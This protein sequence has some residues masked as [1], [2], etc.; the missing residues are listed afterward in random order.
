METQA[1]VMDN[2]TSD[3]GF[4]RSILLECKS[5]KS[6]I[7]LITIDKTDNVNCRVRNKSV[8][9]SIN[10]WQTMLEHIDEIEHHFLQLCQGEEADYNQHIGDNLYVSMTSGVMCVDIRK[11]YLDR[12]SSWKP[13]QPGIGLKLSEFRELLTIKDDVNEKLSTCEATAEE[14]TQILTLQP[15]RKRLPK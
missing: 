11:F 4:N 5:G 6:Y 14:K 12:N 7:E 15:P 3:I 9:L 8:R 2:F 10:V 1:K 13:G